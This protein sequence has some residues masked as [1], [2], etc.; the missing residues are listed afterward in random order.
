M[1]RDRSLTPLSGKPTAHP[2]RR[3]VN[4]KLGF[5]VTAPLKCQADKSAV[6]DG[7]EDQG[8]EEMRS[9]GDRE[10]FSSVLEAV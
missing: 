7:G 3:R 2:V 6:S 1:T 10:S 4:A 9:W 5:G 8:A